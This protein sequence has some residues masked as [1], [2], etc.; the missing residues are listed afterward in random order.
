MDIGGLPQ[1]TIDLGIRIATA[2]SS[3]PKKCGPRNYALTLGLGHELTLG[4]GGGRPR[5][6]SI[7]SQ[8]PP[9]RRLAGSLPLPHPCC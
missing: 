5:R 6:V 4:P 3:R 9:I 1:S 2:T 7:G 8:G